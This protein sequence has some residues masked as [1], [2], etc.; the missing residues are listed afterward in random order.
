MDKG[1]RE[2]GIALDA[3]RTPVA[4]ASYR[5]YVIGLLFVIAIINFFDRQIVN[6]LAEAIKNDL[7]LADWQLGLLTGLSFAALYT[8]FGIPI[9]L[10]ADR[11]NRAMIISG[12]LAF[13]SVFTAVCGLAQNFPQ[14]LMSRLAVGLGEAGCQPPSLSLITDYA[15][16]EKRA[17]ALA[18][19]SLGISAGS[20]V[21]LALG[22]VMVDA[23][24]WRTAFFVAGVPGIA[25][26]VLAFL[27]LRDPRSQ[28]TAVRAASRP[29]RESL[30]ELRRNPVFWWLSLASAFMAMI[31][32]GQLAFFGSFFLR[33]HAD[34][35]KEVSVAL[36]SAGIPLGSTGIV[37]IGLGVIVGVAGILGTF[38]G[39]QLG[40][41]LS[42]KDP[43]AL[44]LLPAVV[45]P[46]CVPF[47]IA[48]FQVPS[49]AWSLLLLFPPKLLAGIWL[50]PTFA[51]LQG[52]VRPDTRAT[53]AALN[54][55]V[56][57][58]I[59]LGLGPVLIGATSD[60]L[61]TAAGLGPVEGVRWALT[62]T[63]AI[64]VLAALFFWVASRK[65][66]KVV[67]S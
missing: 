24:G 34:G 6:I 20:L 46:L 15:P 1:I 21:A 4:S 62:L 47:Y 38:I 35:L 5:R 50:G 18:T 12:S 17:S 25:I 16:K 11:A 27:T 53:A 42:R 67:L 2:D 41:R 61:A 39:G 49:A 59:G 54:S 14:L 3:S 51:A 65:L 13:W 26:A 7:G 10:L 22:G 23:F 19:Y 48:A 30:S 32:Y 8:I 56:V 64:C 58:F 9:A 40:D 63:S 36:A 66:A 33:V 29:I 45:A 60:L 28:K 44:M 31:S 57:L 43:R 37:G 55:S 52:I